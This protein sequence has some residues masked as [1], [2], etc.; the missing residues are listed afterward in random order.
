[1]ELILFYKGYGRL[2]YYD[3]DIIIASKG[4]QL[5]QE[6]FSE[7]THWLQKGRRPYDSLQSFGSTNRDKFVSM[8]NFF[9]NLLNFKTH[10]W[11]TGK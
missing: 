3:D 7:M 8:E 5:L 4:A 11:L 2:K 10:Y 9:V 1:M 6:A